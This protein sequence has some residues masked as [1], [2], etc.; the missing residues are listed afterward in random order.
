MKVLRK[1]CGH[2]G[3]ILL[4]SVEVLCRPGSEPASGEHCPVCKTPLSPSTL[5]TELDME[6]VTE[7]PD[8]QAVRRAI[9]RHIGI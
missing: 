5:F 7:G 9:N 6:E 3:Y 1:V 2:C 8:V 4:F